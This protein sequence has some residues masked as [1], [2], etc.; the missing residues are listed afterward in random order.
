M[1]SESPDEPSGTST[2]TAS[3]WLGALGCRSPSAGCFAWALPSPPVVAVAPPPSRAGAVEVSGLTV[4]R[5]G[6]ELVGGAVSA[7]TSAATRPSLPCD[8][9]WRALRLPS[10]AAGFGFLPLPPPAL[11]SPPAVGNASVY[12]LAAELPGGNTASE[13]SGSAA[14]ADGTIVAAI[15]SAVASPL[16]RLFI[17][18]LGLTLRM[19]R[20]VDRPGSLHR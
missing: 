15:A 14:T 5:G 8:S 7:A 13:P 6:S 9:S 4:C 2:R 16:M 11:R 17:S 10:T 20:I 19:P 3:G 1:T 18:I 12:W